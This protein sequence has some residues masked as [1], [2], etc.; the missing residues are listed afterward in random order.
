MTIKEWLTPGFFD[1]NVILVTLM[2]NWTLFAI[3]SNFLEDFHMPPR[4]QAA[5]YFGA[6]I[7]TAIYAVLL[8]VL[9]PINYLYPNSYNWLL[10]GNWPVLGAVLG[11]IAGGVALGYA[12]GSNRKLLAPAAVL[13]VICEALIV[14]G[15]LLWILN[16][17]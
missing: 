15:T 14:A 4:M 11:G 10:L 3:V 6:I 16:Q 5:N 9:E 2:I 17:E 1:I 13:A 12:A 7:M 8:L